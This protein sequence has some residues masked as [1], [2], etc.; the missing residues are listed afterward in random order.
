MTLRNI[1]TWLSDNP[2]GITSARRRIVA[3]EIILNWMRTEPR[4]STNLTV[5]GGAFKHIRERK[6]RLANMRIEP[7]LTGI[8]ARCIRAPRK[9]RS[10][11]ACAQGSKPES[12]TR[13]LPALSVVPPSETARRNSCKLRSWSSPVEFRANEYAELNCRNQRSCAA[14]KLCGGQAS[15]QQELDV[16]QRLQARLGVL[17]S[18]GPHGRI[19]RFGE[20]GDERGRRRINTLEGSQRR[21]QQGR[22]IDVHKRTARAHNEWG[23]RGHRGKREP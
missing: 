6:I 3:R 19:R 12:P 20:L 15:S 23:H 9:A 5:I 14:G 2:K 1:E 22:M 10:E 16:A 17:R 13:S 11:A 21:R 4:P 8:S 18:D 7:R